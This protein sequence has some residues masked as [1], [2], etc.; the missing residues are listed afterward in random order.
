MDKKSIIGKGAFSNV[1][2]IKSGD[3]YIAM[4]VPND[5][6]SH[7]ENTKY[8]VHE[9]DILSHFKKS[10]YL[11]NMVN[12]NIGDEDN[13]Y[14]C[15]ELLGD[16]VAKLIEHYVDI[17]GLIP[18][19]IVKSICTQVLHGLIELKQ[20]DIFHN[21]LKWENILFTTRLNRI[22]KTSKRKYIYSSIYKAHESHKFDLTYHLDSYYYVLQ[23]LLLMN[24]KVKIT[25]FG[26][27]FTKQ[28]SI[29][30]KGDFLRSRPTRYYMSPERIIKAPV[31]IEADMWSFGCM[32]YELITG[33]VLFDPY[34]DNNMGI[35]SCHIALLKKI[36]GS[37]PTHMLDQ[38][39][40]TSKY[41]ID[42][43]FKFNYIIGPTTNIGSLLKYNYIRK[44]HIPDIVKFLN[45]IL[46][47]DPKKRISPEECIQLE[48]LEQ[49]KI[50]NYVL[51]C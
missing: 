42:N 36:F 17:K 12:Y 33:D 30:R 14:I 1:Y 27:S 32:V 10:Q 31:W 2:K 7:K 9:V 15:T 8:L 11:L 18:L 47:I 45:Y 22:F 43:K 25:D 38:G 41:Y 40:R 26:G 34:R 5:V 21:D 13:T 37:I 28:M 44:Q 39:A 49:S 48:Y 6:L 19:P 46:C 20:H 51:S 50:F 29:E 3:E 16:E 24:M 35:N 23:E 4:K